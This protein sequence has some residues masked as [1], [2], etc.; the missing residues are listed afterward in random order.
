LAFILLFLFSW[1]QLSGYSG[2]LYVK[3]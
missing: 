1:V 3:I 2:F